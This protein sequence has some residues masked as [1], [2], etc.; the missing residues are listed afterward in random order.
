[1]TST[2][3]FSK[4]VC[5]LAASISILLFASLIRC[6]RTLVYTRYSNT[7]TTA[8]INSVAF[9]LTS[10]LL[11]LFS[12]L[13]SSV[14]L[15]FIFDNSSLGI[16]QSC[17]LTGDRRKERKEGGRLKCVSYS[18]CRQKYWYL[19]IVSKLNDLEIQFLQKTDNPRNPNPPKLHFIQLH[20]LLSRN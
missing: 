2:L 6:S 16:N 17:R 8:A 9:I 14:K 20:S 5:T 19:H 13:K 10:S 7:L 12:R 11:R 18:R 4:L 3:F 1:M 15:D